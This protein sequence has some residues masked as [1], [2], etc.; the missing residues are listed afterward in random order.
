MAEKIKQA[1]DLIFKEGGLQ[2]RMRV[3]M[4][5][6]IPSASAASIPDSPENLAKIKAAVEDVFKDAMET[7][8][9][10]IQLLR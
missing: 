5:A 7:K 6:S 3:S 10:I 4:Q 9:K 1:F 2:E 8:K